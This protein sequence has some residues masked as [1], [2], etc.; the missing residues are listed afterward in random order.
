MPQPQQ[1]LHCT[2]PS[3]R[4][5]R[6]SGDSLSLV[7]LFKEFS[8]RFLYREAPSALPPLF[9]LSAKKVLDKACPPFPTVPCSLPRHLDLVRTLP[10]EWTDNQFVH[11]VYCINQLHT[12]SPL[13]LLAP[14]CQP[15]AADLP[16]PS[17]PSRRQLPEEPASCP[18]Q[19]FGSPWPMEGT[20]H[21]SYPTA[22]EPGRHTRPCPFEQ[23]VSRSAF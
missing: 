1:R 8:P 18:S 3:L 6:L 20:P 14:S 4:P 9:P 7:P 13:W 12:L 15:S 21:G 22:G 2:L 5:R 19:V 16:T 10:A 17:N 11:S 23:Q